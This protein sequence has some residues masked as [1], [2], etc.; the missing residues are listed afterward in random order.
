[1][2]VQAPPGCPVLAG[3]DPLDPAELRNPY[4]G[5]KRA[6]DE[7]PVFFEKY[8]FWTITKYDD[9][10]AVLNDDEHY[11]NKLAIPMPLPPE[12]LRDR[13]PVYPFMTALLF[14]DNPEHRAAR[15]MVQEPFIPRRLKQREPRIYSRA[16]ELITQREDR[17]IEFLKEYALPLALTVIGDLVGVPEPDWPLLEESVNGAFEIARIASGVVSDPDEIRRL[18]EGQARYWQYLCDLAEERRRRPTD[19]FSSI[20]AAYRDPET[21]AQPTA[22]EIA[23]HINTMLG[24]GFETSAQLITWGM[25]SMLS[26]PGQWELLKSDRSLIP[27]AVEECV[28][29][30]TVTKRIFRSARVDV[31]VG[32]VTVPEGSLIALSLASANH[33]ESTFGNPE[34]FDIRRPPIPGNLTFG[35]GMHFCLGAPLSKTEMRITLETFLDHAPGAKI[36]GDRELEWKPDY[37]LEAVT[38]LWVDLGPV[39]A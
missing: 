34:E 36:I 14:K 2:E 10:L 27:S 22:D 15:T 18:S 6:R 7:A 24:A 29:H 12:D 33:D 17:Q 20:L 31:E 39:P 13:M 23:A 4:P 25:H 9:V 3:Y 11:S 19:D 5:F 32:G 26:H 38:G 30:R 21:G 8:G 28:R 37:R 1:M 16:Q 35:R